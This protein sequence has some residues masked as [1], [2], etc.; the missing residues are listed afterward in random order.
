MFTR[1][2][3]FHGLPL[4]GLY[5]T[6]Y[7]YCYNNHMQMM[8]I[9]WKDCCEMKKK[10]DIIKIIIVAPSSMWWYTQHFGSHYAYEHIAATWFKM[11]ELYTIIIITE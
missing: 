4:P 2:N 9:S 11:E 3:M 6:V 10:S 7:Y 5:V 1:V 8:K